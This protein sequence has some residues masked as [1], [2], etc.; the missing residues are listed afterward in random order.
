MKPDDESVKAIEKALKAAYRKALSKP[1]RPEWEKQVMSHVYSLTAPSFQGNPWDVPAIWRVAAAVC[2]SA[3]IILAFSLI[4]NL[5]PEY[6]AARLL[7]EDPLGL[8]FVQPLF[9]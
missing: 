5:G 1:V 8:T 3:L 9:P 4:N 2:M 6:E 7:L